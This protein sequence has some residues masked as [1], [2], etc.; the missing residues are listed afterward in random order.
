MEN[1]K[2]ASTPIAPGTIFAKCEAENCNEME[3][4]KSYPSLVGS[5]MYLATISRPVQFAS[6][7]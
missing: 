5:L 3:D 4:V 6:P 1:C 7:P 2:P